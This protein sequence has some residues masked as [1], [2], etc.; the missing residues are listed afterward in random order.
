MSE[1]AALSRWR[2][3]LALASWFLAAT[4]GTLCG[5]GGGIFA[6]PILHYICRKPL[7][8]AISA[9]L[10]LVLV[11]TAIATSAEAVRS[12]GALDWKIVG[13]LLAG[14]VPG[15][16]LGYA[17]GL[18]ASVRVLKSGF[19]ILLCAAAARTAT[20]S[21][22]SALDGPGAT[23]LDWAESA[24]TV[25]IGFGGGILAPL[26]GV[27]GG[28][29]VIP[30]LFLCLPDMGYLEARA[31]SMAMSVVNAG[32]SVALHLRDGRVDLRSTGPMAGIAVL[33][34]LAGAWLIHLPGWGEVARLA[35]TAVLLFVAGRFAWDV[36]GSVRAARE[37]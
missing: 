14:S 3:T 5:I 17:L 22:A 2:S 1:P 26:L 8:R 19:A 25:L 34:A 16:H 23:D 35:L 15:A 28:I 31:A 7:D 12:D 4:V 33:G 11:M 32:Q 24:V 13:L 9:S 27:G 20:M 18:R 6:T 21:A 36:Y 37:R 29:L 30:A 10:V